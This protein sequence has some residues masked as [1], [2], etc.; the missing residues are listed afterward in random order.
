MR[1]QI[2]VMFCGLFLLPLPAAFAEAPPAAVNRGALFKV[3]DASH[4]LYLFGTIHVGAPDFYPL[5]PTVTRA[6]R[7]A[8]ALA[9]EIDPTGDPRVAA[10]AVL[11][12]GMDAPGSTPPAD[13]RQTLAP[14][15]TPLLQKYGIA[16]DAAAPM[17]PWMLASVLAVSEFSALG[18]RAD[19][20]VDSYLAQQ[21]K[22]RR[23]PVLELESMESQLALFAG[24][25][26]ADQCRFLEDSIESIEDKDQ[27]EEARE[28]AQAWRTADAAAFERLAAKAATDPS[29]AARFVQKV[30]LDGRNPKLADGIAKLLK[31]EKNSLAAI[32]VLHLVGKQ[33]VPDLLRKKGLT[34]ERIY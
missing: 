26:P 31:Q 5:E 3:H 24:M 12:Y 14:R 11:K 17:K 10:G 19:L 1:R 22:Q 25:T 28:I 8:G 29:F 4:T 21:A 20:A 23:I 34:V 7:E 2:I 13:C 15:V 33:S 18:Y 27:K 16:P 32:G 30:L 9:L 6:L